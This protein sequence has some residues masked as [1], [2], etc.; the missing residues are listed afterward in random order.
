MT[1][2]RFTPEADAFLNALYSSFGAVS[3][4]QKIN[5]LQTKLKEEASQYF[6]FGG[7]VSQEMILGCLEYEYLSSEGKI[8]LTLA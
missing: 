6:G 7:E 5:V 1:S 4:E 8:D 3:I 2:P